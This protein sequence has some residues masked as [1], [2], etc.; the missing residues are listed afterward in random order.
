MTGVSL[1]IA[2]V[3]IKAVVGKLAEV[4]RVLVSMHG[5]ITRKM[6][7][8][9]CSVRTAGDEVAVVAVT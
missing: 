2:R 5:F 4:R 8:K 6:N 1:L 9:V 3:G 7:K